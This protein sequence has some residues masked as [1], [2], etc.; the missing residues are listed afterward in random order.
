MIGSFPD[1][2]TAMA[3]FME[4]CLSVNAAMAALTGRVTVWSFVLTSL[5]AM[6]GWGLYAL[7]HNHK[8]PVL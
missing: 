2:H 7:E 4:L 3:M 8:T 5:L 1:P 6:A